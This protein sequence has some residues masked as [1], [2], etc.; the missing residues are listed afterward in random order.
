MDNRFLLQQRLNEIETQLKSANSNKTTGV[1]LCV[2][3]IFM[4]WPLLI[5]G[6]IVYANANSKVKALEEE[7]RNI[8]WQLANLVEEEWNDFLKRIK[9]K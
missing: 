9:N 5:V 3:S 6:L 4:L 2:I 7:K 8:N 1:V